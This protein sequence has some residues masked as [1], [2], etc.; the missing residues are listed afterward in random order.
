[1]NFSLKFLNI[2]LKN[3]SFYAYLQ[4]ERIWLHFLFSN[5]SSRLYL[6]HLQSFT[7]KLVY[8]IFPLKLMLIIHAWHKQN[9]SYKT[10]F[11]AKI[12]TVFF[13]LGV[14]LNDDQKLYRKFGDHIGIG[15]HSSN[16]DEDTRYW[17]EQWDD[18]SC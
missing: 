16:K 15:I 12:Y 2:L 1:M 13:L 5:K 7:Y 17:L 4:K 18:W 11:K 10:N 8:S 3:P 14:F 6:Y 9:T